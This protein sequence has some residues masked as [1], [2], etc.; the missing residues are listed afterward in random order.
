MSTGRKPRN[1][2]KKKQTVTIREDNSELLS[3]DL[4][5]T[6]ADALSDLTVKPVRHDN[7]PPSLSRYQNIGK[8]YPGRDNNS[9]NPTP[10]LPTSAPIEEVVPPTPPPSPLPERMPRKP[11]GYKNSVTP[12]KEAPKEMIFE[13]SVPLIPVIHSAPIDIPQV[14]AFEFVPKPTFRIPELKD[15]IDEIINS[16]GEDE[17]EEEDE[18]EEED[19]DEEEEEPN[20]FDLEAE[21]VS[22]AD[23]ETMRKKDEALFNE[24]EDLI[25]ENQYNTQPEPIKE[26]LP[27]VHFGTIPE[28]V[29]PPEP[30]VGEKRRREEEE[31][32]QEDFLKYGLLNILSFTE[33]SP[34]FKGYTARLNNDKMFNAALEECKKKW[35]RKTLSRM[36]PEA[37]LAATTVF[38][39]LGVVGSNMKIIRANAASNIAPTQ[40]TQ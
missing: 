2:R 3:N 11:R 14:S 4:L 7:V 19:Q 40:S 17:D 22:D 29:T 8:K 6:A 28:G 24:R 38:I 37:M 30:Q 23:E 15:P 1:V 5:N 20:N 13:T 33:N 12:P 16:E 31:P 36:S 21:E 39:G 27:E 34:Y 9:P 32:N 10:N 26:K 18:E 25:R 35:R